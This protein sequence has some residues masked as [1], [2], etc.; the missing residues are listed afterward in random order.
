MKRRDFV[1]GAIAATAAIGFSGCTRE[2]IEGKK[3]VNISRRKKVK[4][5]L[6]TSWPANFPIMGTGVDRFAEKV[7]AM[8]GGSLEIKVYPKNILVPALA[9]FDAT[10]SG[11]IDAFHSGPYY[12]KGKNPAF[13]LFSGLPLGMVASELSCWMNYGGGYD[14]WRELYAKFNLYPFVGG[15]TGVQMGGWFRKPIESLAD[16]HGLKMRIPGLGGEVMAKLGV[17]P[18]LLPAGEIYTSLERGTIDATE[19]VGPALDIRMGFYKVARYYYTGWHEPGSI[20][21]L[22]FNKARFESLSEE[23]K[24]ILHYAA[25]AMTAEMYHEFMHENAIA[26]EKLKEVQVDIRDFPPEIIEAAKTAL[27]QVVEEQSGE[28][29]DFKRVFESMERYYRTIKPWSDISE[30]KYLAIR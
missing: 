7:K 26:L 3:N 17:N 2:M 8:S 28:S 14:L 12:W 1:K 30:A 4:L 9:V 11:Q 18:I 20:L 25:E 21:E 24:A 19:W 15:N 6:A 13:A 16:L 23:H 22:T 5:K 10:S 29:S 27:A